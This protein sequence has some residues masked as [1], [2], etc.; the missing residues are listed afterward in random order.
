MKKSY[1]RYRSTY[2]FNAS[3]TVTTMDRL[4]AHTFWVKI[5]I[6]V[7]VDAFV[8]FMTYERQI[9]QYFEKYSSQCIN[10]M[11]SFEGIVPTLENMCKVFFKDIEAIF[12]EV[13]EFS[14]V[15]IELGD[16]PIYSTSVGHKIIA[17][18]ADIV[19]SDDYY[20]KYLMMRDSYNNRQLGEENE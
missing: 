16:G 3:H 19:I 7:N 12:N 8:S 18:N 11:S 5:Y 2:K 6:E 13:D 20:E 17:G 10:R 15:E 1:G 4:H 14:L 9:G